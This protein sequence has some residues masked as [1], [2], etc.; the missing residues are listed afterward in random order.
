MLTPQDLITDGDTSTPHQQIPLSKNIDHDLAKATYSRERN[1]RA[2]INLEYADRGDKT[3]LKNMEF[4]GPLR[5]QRAFYPEGKVCHSYLLHPPGGMV[6]GDQIDIDIKVGANAHA[7]VTTP[8]AGKVYCSDSLDVAQQQQVTLSVE[9]GILEWL[10]QENIVFDGS[11]ARLLTTIK[12]NPDASLIA[13]DMVGLGRQA[14]N[15]PYIS[16]KLC[17]GMQVY[18]EDKPVLLERFELDDQLRLLTSQAGLMGFSQFG[19][20]LIS[21][22]DADSKADL[23]H[24]ALC[25]LIREHL[26]DLDNKEFDNKELDNNDLGNKE[27]ENNLLAAASVTPGILIVRAFAHDAEALRNLFATLWTNLRSEA[28]GVEPCPPRIWFT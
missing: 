16:G 13:W 4:E 11:H 22:P 19:T 25:E 15:L 2:R 6:S 27:P 20:L 8:S 14:G 24:Q 21:L 10:P 12:L 5:V 18:R 1:W 23:R 26:P 17:Q 9:G 7:L 3:V 28:I